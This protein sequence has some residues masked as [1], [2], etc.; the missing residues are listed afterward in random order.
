MK[1]FYAIL[2]LILV[3]P[4]VSYAQKMCTQIG[5]LDGLTLRID[6]DYDWKTGNYDLYF[7]LGG[8]SVICRGRLPLKPCDD[9]PTFQCGGSGVTIGESGC[10]LPQNAHAISD[11]HIEGVPSTVSVIIKHNGQT[12]VTRRMVPEYQTSQ[13]NGEG[14]GPVCKS[15]SYDLFTA[16]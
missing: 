4:S 16:Q 1:N 3:F 15:A 7:N 13:P 5:C 8:K 9:G 10:A 6:P 12:I 11:I 14:C 2:F